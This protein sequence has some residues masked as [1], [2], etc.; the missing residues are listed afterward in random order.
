MDYK[1]LRYDA[2]DGVA[3][4]TYDSPERRNAWN[5]QMY[6]EIVHAVQHANEDESVGAIVFT[7]EGPIFCAG[8]DLKAPPE[9]KDPITGV[10][11]NIATVSMAQNASWVHLLAQSKPTI[12]AIRGQAIGMGVTQI[13]AMDIRVGG[14]SSSYKFPFLSL[15]LMPELGATALLP[16]L[17]GYGRAVDLCLS[18]ATV[19]ADEAYR[20][21]LIS[22]LV[23]D[24]QVREEA[25]Q[26]GARIASFPKLQ[27]GLTKKLFAENCVETDPNVYLQREIDAFIEMFKA[28][29]RAQA[30]P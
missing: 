30:T 1:S 7:H 24:D 20:I 29:K 21:G 22:R 3:V 5:L 8:T 10:R 28:R 25:I 4:I 11:P 12:A 14:R 16:R 27:V 19:D 23:R 26:L 17:V 13:L 15:Q 6:A 18:A 9:Q 2:H